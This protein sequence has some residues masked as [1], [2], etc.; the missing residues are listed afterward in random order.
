MKSVLISYAVEG[1]RETGYEQPRGFCVIRNTS[2][3]ETWDYLEQ[4]F[5]L[6]GNR[7][8]FN[9]VIYDDI[10]ELEHYLL[11]QQ[12]PKKWVVHAL[13]DIFSTTTVL[14]AWGYFPRDWFDGIEAYIEATPYRG[15]GK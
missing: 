10:A 14:R 2:V 5:R 15:V 13:E 8:V 6:S 1:I 7:L 3:G 11:V 9:K 12:L 4:K